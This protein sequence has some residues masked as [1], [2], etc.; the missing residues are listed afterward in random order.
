MVKSKVRTVCISLI[1]RAQHEHNIHKHLTRL[2][3]YLWLKKCNKCNFFKIESPST[4]QLQ[5]QF[6]LSSS[7]QLINQINDETYDKIGKERQE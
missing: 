6:A 4:C 2:L 3:P 7:P 1:T 5:N